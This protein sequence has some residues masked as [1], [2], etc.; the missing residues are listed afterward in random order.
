MKPHLLTQFVAA[1]DASRSRLYLF[2]NRS[3]GLTLVADF[4]ISVG[5]SGVEKNAE[6]DLRTPMG[7]YFITSNLDPKSRLA[8]RAD[9]GAGTC[10]PAQ[11]SVPSALDGRHRYHG[12]HIWQ[13]DRWHPHG[14]DQAPILGAARQSMD[15]IF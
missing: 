8:H 6:G 11:G 5:K 13:S 7:V 4:Y 3:T 12:G 9:E 1:A 10:H 14:A 15:N 2:E